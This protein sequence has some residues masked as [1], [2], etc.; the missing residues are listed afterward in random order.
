MFNQPKRPAILI[1]GALAG[2]INCRATGAAAPVADHH[3]FDAV[4]EAPFHP[5]ADDAAPVIKLHFSEPG[6]RARRVA[7]RLAL[8][9]PDG[10]RLRLWR[11]SGRLR[12]G[13]LDVRLPWSIRPAAAAPAGVYQLQLEA[14][15]RSR[16]P[17]RQRWDIAIGQPPALAM[18]AFAMLPTAHAPR[19]VSPAPD[20]LPYTVYYGNLH[21]QTSHSDGG[22]ALNDCHGAQAPQS[23]PF[24]PA[25]AYDYAR[26]HGLDFL[27]TSEHNHMYD[28]SEGSAP[29][30]DPARAKALYRQGLASAAD[31]SAA[32]PGFLAIY[33]M[34]W[35]VISN[36]GH[37][38]ILNSPELLG[39]ERNAGGDLLADTFTAKG[40]YD[41]LYKLMRQRG[42]LGQFNH[43]KSN[44]FRAGGR[45]L[46]YSADG[47]AAMALCE[48]MNSSAFSVN[49]TETEGQRS[50]Y[51]E[52]CRQAL[53]AGYH[54]AFSSN[55]DNHCANWGAA[56]SNRTAVLIP[57]GDALSAVSLLDAV[58]ARRVFATMDRQAQLVMTANGHLM[59]ERFSNTGALTLEV[60]YAHAAGRSVAALA[61]IA[62]T[63]GRKNSA[64]ALPGAGASTTLT[65]APGEHFYY[66]RLTQDDGKILWSAP[67]WVTQLPLTTAQR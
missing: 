3:E 14:D 44:Q 28:G 18:P 2:A 36:G 55:Q 20:A 25:D 54:V 53:E 7:W 48:V 37:L 35:G 50:N 46:G 29:D 22:G 26:R 13:A 1:A 11:G 33:G 15:T 6:A 61:I 19:T 12:G 58:R 10:R 51:E 64:S 49:A 4:L 9:A 17:L 21:S 45:G 34:E 67:V 41:A 63:P 5:G 62:G 8:L 65:P 24:G 32:H 27:M 42:W 16:Q 23:A 60:H 59:G 30:A 38:N 66:A 57:D 43:P 31:Y 47:D 56:Y 40:D 39:W 52:V